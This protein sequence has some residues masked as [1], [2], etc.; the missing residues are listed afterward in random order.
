MTWTTAW[1]DMAAQRP[2]AR[3]VELM[4]QRAPATVHGPAR[5]LLWGELAT[6]LDL[7]RRPFQPP[8]VLPK[9]KHPRLVMLL[10]GFGTHPL[11]M[12]Y[13]AQ[14]LERAGHKVKRWGLGFNL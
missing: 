2:I 14:Q 9:A 10:P 12:R 13:M 4:R 11:R 1:A 8:L 5:K 3:R 7:L 6:P